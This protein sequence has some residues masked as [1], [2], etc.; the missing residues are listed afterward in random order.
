MTEILEIRNSR[1]CYAHRVRTMLFAAAIARD[2]RRVQFATPVA[3]RPDG[4]DPRLAWPCDRLV[5]VNG[6]VE[7]EQ[8]ATA[9]GWARRL[10]VRRI[11]WRRPT[12]DLHLMRCEP[13]GDR[14]APHAGRA[15]RFPTLTFS[16]RCRAIDAPI[17]HYAAFRPKAGY[18][19]SSRSPARI[20]VPCLP[21]LGYMT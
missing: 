1:R 8:R 17:A 3:R 7:A 9:N 12:C 20:R 16:F 4:L 19:C 18:P 5:L 2:A 14:R 21:N 6:P 13:L 10:R 15:S 11:S